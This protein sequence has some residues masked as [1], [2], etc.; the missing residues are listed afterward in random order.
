MQIAQAIYSSSSEGSEEKRE[1][2]RLL[3]ARYQ[4]GGLTLEQEVQI[5][6]A[7]YR[8]SPSGSEEKRERLKLLKDL[9]QRGG[10]TLEQEVQIA[11]AIYSLSPEGS[12]EKREG[13]QLLNRIVQN[14]QVELEV[15]LKLA[16]LPC[17]GRANNFGERAQAIKML[18]MITEEEKARKLLKVQWQQPLIIEEIMFGS[19]QALFGEQ[20]PYDSFVSAIPAIFELIKQDVLPLETR[21]TLYQFLQKMIPLF[22][23]I[24]SAF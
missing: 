23:K 19:Q 18:L 17:E 24:D 16:L 21:N 1:G 14:T 20:I 13:F 12:E 10:L 6:Q 5:A 8:F 9:I 3:L 15:R 22:T 4:R 2:A 11:Q 7:I